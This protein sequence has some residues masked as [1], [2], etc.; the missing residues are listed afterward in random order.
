MSQKE[1][2][3]KQRLVDANNIIIFGRWFYV[4]AIGITAIISKLM[5][6]IGRAHV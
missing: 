4:G 1:E 5:G 6:E 3:E 2:R